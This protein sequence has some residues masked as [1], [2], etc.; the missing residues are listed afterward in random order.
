MGAF[1]LCLV[2]ATPGGPAQDLRGA[3]WRLPDESKEETPHFG[4]GEGQEVHRH[5]DAVLVGGRPFLRVRCMS[6][7]RWA[8]SRTRVR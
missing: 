4:H 3:R 6:C 1:G 8:W 2:T 5:Y 7:A